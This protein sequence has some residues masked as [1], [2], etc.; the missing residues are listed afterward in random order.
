M[1]PPRQ[2]TTALLL[3]ALSLVGPATC[4]RG[5]SSSPPFRLAL[6]PNLTHA[7][8][9]VGEA[10]GLFARAIAA[11]VVVR[12]FHAGPAAME[13]LLAG[14][15]DMAYVGPGPAGIAYLRSG[16]EALRVVA[17]AASGGAGLVARRAF[18]ARELAGKRV[19]T[20]Q[21]GNTQD[22]ALRFWLRSQGLR[23]GSGPSDVNVLPL[24]NPDILGL[25]ARGEIEAAWVPEPWAALLVAKAGGH[26]VVDER[27]LWEGRQF[28]VAVVV[29]SRRA[30]AT[31]R[32][33]VVAA[34]RVHLALTD[35][36][37][38]DPAAFARAANAQYGKLTAHPLPDAVLLDAFS[39]LQ[40]TTDPLERQLEIGVRRAQAMKFAPAG[41]VS[42]MVDASALEEAARPGGDHPRLH[43]PP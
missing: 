32:R 17:G 6:F 7:Q 33:E 40:P 29:A 35:R 39:R 13:A 10:E 41:D 5:S 42:R 8:G 20:P 37:R 2:R 15:I 25:F 38:S 31:R 11:P 23:V 18:S 12:H 36:W 14:D 9:L 24:S 22:I 28:P 43:R 26:L 27:D 19:A 34:L 3:T 16:E 4:Q 21:L 1:N 30:L